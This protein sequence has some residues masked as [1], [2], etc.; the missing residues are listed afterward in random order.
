MSQFRQITR[1]VTLTA[2]GGAADRLRCWDA[3]TGAP[4]TKLSIS[5]NSGGVETVA[6]DLDWEVFYGGKWAGDPFDS[7]STHSGG[8]SQASGTITGS[9]EICILIHEDA[10]LLPMNNP[11]RVGRFAGFSIV[12]ELKNDK[13][14]AFTAYVTFTTETIGTNA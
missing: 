8:V 9:D 10:S 13:A 5:I 2:S 12:V 7:D 11:S 6:G 1:T 4:I 14:A 3:P